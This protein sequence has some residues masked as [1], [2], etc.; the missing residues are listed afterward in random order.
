MYTVYTKFHNER[1]HN[2]QL[3]LFL[4]IKILKFFMK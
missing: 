4:K 1:I 3:A 2:L